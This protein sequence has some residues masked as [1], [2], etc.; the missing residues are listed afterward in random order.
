MQSNTEVPSK[1]INQIQCH[2]SVSN[3]EDPNTGRMEASYEGDRKETSSPS[4]SRSQSTTR[5]QTE[6]EPVPGYD[7]GVYRT[8]ADFAK[9][10]PTPSRYLIREA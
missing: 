3:I 9:G 6:I 2:T 1:D 5:T 10:I 7:P 8:A 4:P